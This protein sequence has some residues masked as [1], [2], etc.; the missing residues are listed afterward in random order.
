M[1]SQAARYAVRS[2]AYLD[3]LQDAEYVSVRIISRELDISGA[4]LGKILKP[5]SAAKLIDTYRGPK[6]G[7]RLAR[8]SSSI[9]VRDVI[10]AVDG[11]GLFKDCILGLP[12]CGDETPCPMHKEWAA[13]REQLTR[14]LDAS[15]IDALATGYRDSGFRL[16]AGE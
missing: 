14:T 4:F 11:K 10:E 15:T 1:I 3:S 5:L 16:S 9:T 13:Q 12:G 7:I 2:L 6:G 8:A